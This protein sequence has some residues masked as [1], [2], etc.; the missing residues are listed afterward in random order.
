MADN[1][2]FGRD[3]GCLILF[4]RG[5]YDDSGAAAKRGCSRTMT[6]ANLS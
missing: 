2:K 3:P 1:E 5:G 4:G 6:L